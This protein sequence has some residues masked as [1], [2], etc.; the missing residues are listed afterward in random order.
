M[1]PPWL[2]VVPFGLAY[3]VTAR[4]AGLSL[5]ETQSLSVFVFSGAAQVSAAGLF[6]AGAAG[7]TIVLTTFLHNIRHV[8]YGLSLGRS[9]ALSRRR[10]VVASYPRHRPGRQPARGLACARR[11]SR[12]GAR[13]PRH[14]ARGRMTF[15]LIAAGML[16][17]TSSSRYAGL[18]FRISLAPFWVRFLHFVPV[19]VFAALVAPS[20]EGDL[21]EGEIRLAAAALAALAAWRTKQLWVGIAVGMAAF[22]LL[23]VPF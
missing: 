11:G 18:A 1:V 2:G 8:L 17:A 3:A 15:A 5:L 4:D 23:R 16:A 22:W 12:R 7:I 14:G 20:V 9:M 6:A 19:A 21:G 10:R 13:P